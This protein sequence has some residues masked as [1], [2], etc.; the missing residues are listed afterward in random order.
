VILVECVP[1]WNRSVITMDHLANGFFRTNTV[2]LC[3]L[4]GKRRFQFMESAG[5]S[6]ILLAPKLCLRVRLSLCVYR[7]HRNNPGL[8]P[9]QSPTRVVRLSKVLHLPSFSAKLLEQ[10]TT[11]AFAVIESGENPRTH[12]RSFLGSS[13]LCNDFPRSDNPLDCPQGRT[14]PQLTSRSFK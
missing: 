14:R 13:A 4:T 9:A 3:T 8:P 6:S 10:I 12:S 1:H 11:G 2:R 7:E 5:V